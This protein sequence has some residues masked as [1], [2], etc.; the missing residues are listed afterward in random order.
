[1]ILLTLALVTAAASLFRAE[2]KLIDEGSQSPAPVISFAI[3][4]AWLKLVDANLRAP[5]QAE[6][7]S[8]LMEREHSTLVPV[9]PLFA[10]R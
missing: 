7:P 2:P 9:T 4:K 5:A 3:R 6:R 1:M 10:S 8:C